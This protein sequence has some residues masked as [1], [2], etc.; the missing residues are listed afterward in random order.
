VGSAIDMRCKCLLQAI[1]LSV[2]QTLLA[3]LDAY[4]KRFGAG[5]L[6]V[7]QTWSCGVCLVLVLLQLEIFEIVAVGCAGRTE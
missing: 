7:I 3:A 4:L 6:V 1:S 2:T 5:H